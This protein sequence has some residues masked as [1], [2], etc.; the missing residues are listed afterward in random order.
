MPRISERARSVARKS[1]LM[2]AG[3]TAALVAGAAQAQE[4]TVEEIVVTA[5]RR[6][7]TLQNT[8]ISIIAL[9]G[10]TVE[11]KGIDDVSDLT[12]F[13]PNL[14]IQPGRFSGSNTPTYSIRGISGGGGAT[15][16]RGVA[17][18]ID[19][20]YVPRTTGSLFRV[21]DIDRI[22]VLR[23]PQGT[24]FGRNS[25]GGAIRIVTKQPVNE[26]D[27]YVRGTLGNFDHRDIVGMINIP[28][29]DTLAIRAQGGWLH[30]DGYV[31]RGPQML[32]GNDDKMFRVQAKW[33]VTPNFE[34]TFGVFYDKTKSDGNP[35]VISEF[36]MRPGI[37]G[38][39]QGNFGDWLNDAFKRAGGAP[40]APYNDPRVVLGKD[41]ETPDFCF[42]DDFNP[43]WDPL[44]LQSNN[45]QYTQ[46]DAKLVWKFNEKV[47]L[48]STTGWSSLVHTGRTDSQMTGFSVAPD[49]VK[50]KVVFQEFQLN[51]LLFDDKLDLVA[52]GNY[53]RESSGTGTTGVVTRRGTSAF[54]ATANGD[55]DA[56]LFVT[57]IGWSRG[58]SDSF[59][60]FASGTWHITNK[61]NATGGVRWGHD[62]K[63]LDQ[64]AYRSA[65]FTPA[66]GTDFTEVTA[67]HRWSA[68]DWRGTID[69]HFTD[70][71]MLYGT[72]SKAYKAGAYSF[73][74]LANIPGP[75]QSGDFIKPIPPEKVIN[76]E[77]GARTTWFNKRLRINPTLFYMDWTSRQAPRQISCVSEGIT[78]CPT[79]FRINLVNTGDITL[80]GLELDG[81]WAVMR[82]FNIDFSL[83]LTKYK[84]KD[85]VANGGPNLYP[86]QASPSYTIGGNYVL[87]MGARG[88]INF[89]LSYSYLD[90]Q[91]THPEE[92]TDSSYQLPSY[93]VVNGRATW[94]SQDRKISVAL[95]ANNLLDK[96]YA[97]YATSAGGGFWDAGGPPN[98]ANAA[99][100]PLRRALGLTMARPREFGVTVQYNF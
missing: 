18:Y 24:L 4:A 8:P 88:D 75:Q 43:D 48:T 95:F 60:L 93:S 45:T 39:I 61:L 5:E 9:S 85:P 80:K 49:D 70:E 11:A 100:F 47:T 26:F 27:A 30:E 13:T 41:Y 6:E 32:G 74:I 59:G 2:A 10:N 38:V 62:T 28:V 42:L 94:R 17:M 73:T 57:G 31:K 84:L 40:L 87:A 23:G 20:I 82:N 3:A 91:P 14:A 12:L 50:S 90:D 29:S 34:A 22:E 46:A 53:F 63:S 7:T 1:L 98:P 66:P 52:G 81:Q 36:D 67:D 89:N 54:P 78:A 58:T 83:G 37:E 16:E 96:V 21:F 86:A 56:G 65:S 72:V 51:A 33:D 92:G 99:Q 19:G 44:C 76:Y 77:V 64:V 15:G 35:Q 25:T 79:G 97:T 68:V 69:Y 55:N 71:A